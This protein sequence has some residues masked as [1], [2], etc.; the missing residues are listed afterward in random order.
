MADVSRIDDCLTTRDG[1]LFIEECDTVELAERF[2]TPLFVL[3][4]TQLRAN[5]RR[6]KRA[7]A[8]HWTDGPVDVLPAIKANW[9]LAPR[10]IA[11]REGAGADVYS[12]GELHAALAAGTA[13][14]L[15]SV[16]GGGK[17]EDFL[18]KCVE[19][20]VRYKLMSRFV[21]WFTKAPNKKMAPT[22]EQYAKTAVTALKRELNR[23][24]VDTKGV[25]LQLEPG[26][27]LYGD[28][29]THL[30]RV[31]K[32]KRQTA[33]VRLA[34]VLLDTTYFFMSGGVYEYNFN[35]FIWANRTDDRPTLVADIV[36]HSCYAD[37]I[38]PFVRVPEVRPGD[39][40]AMLDMGAYQEVSASNFNA[41]PRPAM[42]LVKGNEAE[43]IKRAETV[44]EVYGRDIVPER[45]TG[46]QAT[47]A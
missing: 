1:R 24:G 40:L 34:W 39:L 15:I 28:V 2:G 20:G 4:E 33:P 21:G 29:G 7:F 5:V 35:H 9:S 45:L 38:L 11:S 32:V 6:F 17:T 8:E 25:R 13:P 47:A 23:A 22:I 26:R 43:V 3:S 30:A 37:R 42:V 19:A 36:G 41:L 27:G 14:E 10:V 44:E 12:E 31:K 18:V 16:N 46:R